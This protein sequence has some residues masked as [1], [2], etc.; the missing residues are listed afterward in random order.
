MANIEKTIKSLESNNYT[1]LLALTKQSQH[2]KRLC[3]VLRISL[4]L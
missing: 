2:L 1:V 3:G 4:P